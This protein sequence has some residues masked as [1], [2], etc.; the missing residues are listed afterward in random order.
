MVFDTFGG[1]PSGPGLSW[2]P[3]PVLACGRKCGRVCG[4]PIGPCQILCAGTVLRRPPPLKCRKYRSDRSLQKL[5]VSCGQNTSWQNKSLEAG[6][7]INGERPSPASLLKCAPRH[8]TPL[9]GK[10]QG[11]SPP[12]PYFLLHTESSGPG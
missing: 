2:R 6:P 1:R 5:G 7:L 8:L 10:M 3:W 11:C 4:W 9:C 12:P